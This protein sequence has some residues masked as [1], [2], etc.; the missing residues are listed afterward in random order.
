MYIKKECFIFVKKKEFKVIY[1]NFSFL[2]PRFG[3]IHK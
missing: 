2:F 1:T 3:T